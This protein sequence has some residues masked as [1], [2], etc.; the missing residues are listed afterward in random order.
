VGK[1]IVF[2]GSRIHGTVAGPAVGTDPSESPSTLGTELVLDPSKSPHSYPNRG[3]CGVRPGLPKDY[4]ASFG[5]QID[6]LAI[7]NE[8]ASWV[9]L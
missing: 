2:A 4:V 5:L 8:S 9:V 6:E 3:C 1:A 7:R